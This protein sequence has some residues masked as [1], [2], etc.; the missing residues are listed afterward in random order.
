MRSAEEVMR[1]GRRSLNPRL[2]RAAAAAS[3]AL[4]VFGAYLPAQARSPNEVACT[5][6]PALPADQV[7]AGCTAVISSEKDL[8]AVWPYERRGRA[9][10]RLSQYDLAIHDYNH[11]IGIKPDEADAYVDRGIAYDRKGQYDLAI[12]DLDLA[13]RLKSDLPFAYHGRAQSYQDMGNYDQAI[14]DYSQAIKLSP[15]EADLY[16]DRGVDYAV[17][18]QYD[19]AVRDFDTLL[20]LRPDA[21]AYDIRCWGEVIANHSLEALADCN[22]SLRLRPRDANT[23]QSRSLVYLRLRRYDE[24]IAD[25]TAALTEKANL[26]AALYVRG[27]ARI[28]KG[29]RAGGSADL[30]AATTSDPGIS[31][32][33][34]RYGLNASEQP[35]ALQAA[36]P[37]TG[38][39]DPESCPSPF[40]V[41]PLW[42]KIP[43]VQDIS[44]LYPPHARGLHKTDIV[45]MSCTVLGDGHL[46]DCRVIIDAE[47][48]LGF[49]KAT[50][51]L[52]PFFQ[53]APSSQKIDIAKTP[54]CEGR[55]GQARLA[56]SFHWKLE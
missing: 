54:S 10:A 17:H 9:Y 49:D 46:T 2:G 21:S 33:Y 24:A 56:V 8:R 7:I 5:G 53:A 50:L 43:Q 31:A 37:K 44:L 25:D 23:L 26:A 12:K 11:V 41:H 28:A 3:F 32:D 40:I 22:A 36:V 4:A 55:S 13:I 18:G 27:L 38:L 14:Q 52:A 48:G 51:S 30:A 15:D 29:D 47:P 16:A 39:P 42:M 6:G 45:V 1:T 34:A 19:R 20:L 35:A